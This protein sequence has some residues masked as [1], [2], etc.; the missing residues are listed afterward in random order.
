MILKQYLY[1]GAVVLLLVSHGF[2]YYKG[3]TSARAEA[4]ELRLKDLEAT[5]VIIDKE[6]AR[7]A[8]AEEALR[9]KLNEPEA[10]PKIKVVVREHPSGC[11]IPKPVDDRMRE[12]INKANSIIRATQ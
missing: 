4:V 2:A 11:I 9:E 1:A 12:S 8:K 3:G 10:A 7:A 6:R 5:Q